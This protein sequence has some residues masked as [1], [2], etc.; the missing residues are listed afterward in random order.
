MARQN[1]Q[2]EDR[3]ERLGSGEH[4]AQF[5]SKIRSLITDGAATIVPRK[6]ESEE[7]VA[8]LLSLMEDLAKRMDLLD[9]KNR[10]I[11]EENRV[12]DRRDRRRRLSIG[13]VAAVLMLLAIG[14]WV[15]S[16]IND[17]ST[18]VIAMD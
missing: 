3:L 10:N 18:S 6:P 15:K 5:D 13:V 8:R 9:R 12:R 4:R 1:D 16:R 17:P 14:G 7:Q 2:F 11:A